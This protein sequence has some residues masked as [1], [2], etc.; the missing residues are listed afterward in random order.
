MRRAAATAAAVSAAASA[1]KTN[2]SAP[3]S[4][5]QNTF[6]AAPSQPMSPILGYFTIPKEMH[7]PIPSAPSTPGSSHHAKKRSADDL[8]GARIAK[9]ARSDAS[10]SL[11][12]V[13]AGWTGP[14][15]V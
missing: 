15:G 14:Y 8:S 13:E 5:N 4:P 9:S 6:A 1:A 2:G 3:S 7:R 11:G 12:E 10:V